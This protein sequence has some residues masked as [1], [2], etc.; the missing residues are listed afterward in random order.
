MAEL[1]I[2][3]RLAC[4]TVT[5]ALSPALGLETNTPV[6]AR[7]A[8]CCGAL[9]TRAHLYGVRAR[10]TKAGMVTGSSAPGS[11]HIAAFELWVSHTVVHAMDA[12]A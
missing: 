2:S 4:V 8:A 6:I 12:P 9:R 10:T 1:P 11:S 5:H 7:H 3:A